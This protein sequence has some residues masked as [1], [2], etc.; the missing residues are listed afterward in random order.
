MESIRR[1]SKGLTSLV[2]RRIFSVNFYLYCKFKHHQNKLFIV[3]K[4]ILLKFG[5][6]FIDFDVLCYKEVRHKISIEQSISI[7]SKCK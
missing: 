4:N 7:N 1:K 2:V 5:R 3:K 6:Y